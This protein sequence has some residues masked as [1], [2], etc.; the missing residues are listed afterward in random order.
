MRGTANQRYCWIHSYVDV[1]RSRSEGRTFTFVT[2]RLFLG[3]CSFAARV[4]KCK[5]V[6]RE[7][8]EFELYSRV[9]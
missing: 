5:E 2:V 4:I 7:V 8:T 9:R 1:G 3:V 6:E